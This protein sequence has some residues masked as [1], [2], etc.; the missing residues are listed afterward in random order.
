MKSYVYADCHIDY[1]GDHWEATHP[2]HPGLI[3]HAATSLRV[4]RN[5]IKRRKLAGEFPYDGSD[6][7]RD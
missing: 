5:E 2:R 6:P 1:V 3:I 4:V 7:W